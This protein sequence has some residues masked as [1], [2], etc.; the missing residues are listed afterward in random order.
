MSAV[1][2]STIIAVVVFLVINPFDDDLGIVGP[3]IGVLVWLGIILFNWREYL[4]E[5][6]LRI[7]LINSDMIPCPDC[8]YN[9]TGLKSTRC[10]ECGAWYSIDQ[11]FS[12]LAGKKHELE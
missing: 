10:P 2:C 4:S 12:V 9:L 7:K 5:R 11:V 3:T 6:M 8:G 1:I